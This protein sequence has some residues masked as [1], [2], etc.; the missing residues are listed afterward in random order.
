MLKLSKNENANSVVCAFCHKKGRLRVTTNG[1]IILQP[2]EVLPDDCLETERYHYKSFFENHG[3]GTNTQKIKFTAFASCFWILVMVL[4]NYVNY[5]RIKFRPGVGSHCVLEYKKCIK[6]FPLQ[7]CSTALRSCGSLSS[8]NFGNFVFPTNDLTLMDIIAPQ[9]EKFTDKENVLNRNICSQTAGLSKNL[10]ENLCYTT[11]FSIFED[12]KF[13]DSLNV[14]N[15]YPFYSREF[16]Y[17]HTKNIECI[18]ICKYAAG[19][20]DKE[21]CPYGKRCPQGCPC[22]GYKCVKGLSDHNLAIIKKRDGPV[23]DTEL[24]IDLHKVSQPPFTF[25]KLQHGDKILTDTDSSFC[26]VWFQGAHYV[27]VTRFGTNI[28]VYKILPSGA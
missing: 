19:I 2:K 4:A 13:K 17:N 1:E 8:D 11:R 12:Q 16:T 28:L 21:D 18:G 20:E 24:S 25:S 3:F 10:C 14:E 9:P 7:L 27:L 26:T 6:S 22:V 5:E 23:L 15:P